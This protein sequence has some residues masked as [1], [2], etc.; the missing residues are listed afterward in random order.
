ME[1]E[2]IKKKQEEIAKQLE[3]VPKPKIKAIKIDKS[4]GLQK[5]E[6]C[7]NMVEKLNEH[8]KQCTAKKV[9]EEE[10]LKYKKD[11]KQLIEE[12]MKLAKKLYSS[13]KPIMD[14]R[15]DNEIAKKLQKELKPIINT[16]KD[17]EIAKMLQMEFM[18]NDEEMGTNG[19]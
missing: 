11:I 18:K 14:T 9:L 6:F 8:Y 15:Q 17:E 2:R 10:Q 19:N 1:E 12:D 13:Q 16:S 4:L 5:C 3:S 7:Y